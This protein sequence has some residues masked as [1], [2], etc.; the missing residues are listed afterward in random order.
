MVG[1]GK[2]PSTGLQFKGKSL[3][4]PDQL[5]LTLKSVTF[6]LVHF[7]GQLP[8]P[9]GQWR[10][11]TDISTIKGNGT[12]NEFSYTY[13]T[14]ANQSLRLRGRLEQNLKKKSYLSGDF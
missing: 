7:G 4:I 14:D 11:N 2:A 8:V 13:T 6:G 9:T 12:L 3:K 1:F 10:K 5:F